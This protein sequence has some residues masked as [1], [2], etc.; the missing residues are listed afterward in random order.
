MGPETVEWLGRGR[1]VGGAGEGV[2]GEPWRA[3]Q[4]QSAERVC[5][6]PVLP[7]GHEPLGMGRGGV[8]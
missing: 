6:R 3:E 7:G 8:G 2:G 1:V 4:N 5:Q